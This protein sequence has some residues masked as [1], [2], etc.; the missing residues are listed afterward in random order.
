MLRP[1]SE[2]GLALKPNPL[3]VPPREMFKVVPGVEVMESVPDFEPLSA[4]A[5]ERT[6]TEQVWPELSVPPEQ[7]SVH[8]EISKSEEPEL[9][10]ADESD[11][12][13][14]PLLVMVTA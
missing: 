8:P 12:D 6:P 13:A 11:V 7:V 2:E 10:L 3:T 9:I 5:M 14:G 1:V 4:D